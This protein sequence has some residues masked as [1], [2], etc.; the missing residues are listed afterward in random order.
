M[1]RVGKGVEKGVKRVGKTLNLVQAKTISRGIIKWEQTCD[2]PK[3]R[4]ST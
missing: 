1:K 4:C 3:K 2:Q